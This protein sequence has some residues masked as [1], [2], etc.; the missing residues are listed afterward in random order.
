MN[1]NIYILLILILLFYINDYI[2][3]IVLLDKYIKSYDINYKLLNKNKIKLTNFLKK[4]KSRIKTNFIIPHLE[5]GDNIV[6]NGM[7]RYYLEKNNVVLVCKYMYKKQI[8]YMYADI[9]NNNLNNNINKLYIYDISG[10]EIENKNIYNELPI[11]DSIKRYMKN[12]NIELIIFNSYKLYYSIIPINYTEYPDY[13]YSDVNIN[14]KFQYTKFKIPRNFETENILYN[15]LINLIGKKYIIIIDDEK[16]NFLIK[17]KYISK[18]IPIFKI[19]LNS[20]NELDQLNSIKD[21][22]MFNYIKILENAY[23]IHTIDTSLLLLID[24]LPI[25]NDTYRHVYA[26]KTLYANNTVNLKNKS[27]KLIYN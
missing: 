11:D 8:E 24:I 21:I 13:L 4:I 7:I 15:K 22:N 9:L 18:K 12:N 26:K 14:K 23:E 19:G 20:N 2:Y 5:I 17:D 10:G 3:Y 6:I 16:R 25:N 27:I 1:N